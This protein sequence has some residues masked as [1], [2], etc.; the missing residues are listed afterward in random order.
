MDGPHHISHDATNPELAGIP[1]ILL[2][3]KVQGVD[4]RRFADLGVAQCCSK[5]FNRS[6]WQTRSARSWV[7][8]G[9]MGEACGEA[10]APMIAYDR[11]ASRDDMNETERGVRRRRVVGHR[12]GFSLTWGG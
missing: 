5:P 2:T 1:V 4:L 7:G 12:L 11:D 8:Q 6:R 9:L 3:A 10:R